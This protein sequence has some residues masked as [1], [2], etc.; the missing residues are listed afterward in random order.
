MRFILSVLVFAAIMGTATP[1]AATMRTDEL[2]WKCRGEDQPP[3]IGVSAC[4]GFVS[5]FIDAFALI[6]GMTEGRTRFFC[7][8]GRG[9]S[10]DQAIRI[11]IKW[12]NE[13]PG[14]LHTTA[15]T[16]LMLALANTFPCSAPR[17]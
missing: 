6:D 1:A 16:T 11:F 3:M 8:P 15:R 12:A 10:N 5:G 13:H 4:I 14:D 17:K 2:L 7:L 9:I